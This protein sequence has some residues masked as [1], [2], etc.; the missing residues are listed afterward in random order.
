MKI[1]TH[2]NIARLSLETGRQFEP[3]TI[4]R[5]IRRTAFCYGAMLP[6]FRPGRFLHEHF[7]KRSGD[8]VFQTLEKI[9][10]KKTMSLTDIIKLGEMSHYL[11]DFCCK[12]HQSGGVGNPLLHSSYERKMNNYVLKNFYRLREGFIEE[13][14]RYPMIWSTEPVM[15]KLTEYWSGEASIEHDLT[16]SVEISGLLYYGIVAWKM[17]T[18]HKKYYTSEFLVLTEN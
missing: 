6:D 18:E 2:Y 8:Y 3:F 16:K 10:S 13:C 15:E 5:W 4:E 1:R 12:V 17:G 7:Y 11:S 14:S 9:Q